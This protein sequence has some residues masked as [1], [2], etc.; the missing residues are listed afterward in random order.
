[1]EPVD[2]RIV[3]FFNALYYIVNAGWYVRDRF[4]P[5]IPYLREPLRAPG[6]IASGVFI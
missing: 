2:P 3:R 5:L 4:K 6:R 1:M